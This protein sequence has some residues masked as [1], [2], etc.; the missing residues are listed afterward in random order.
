MC[1]IILASATGN[2]TLTPNQLARGTHR[3]TATYNGDTTYA[4]STSSPPQTLTV[5]RRG[6]G[7]AN[8]G[9]AANGGH[10]RPLTWGRPS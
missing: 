8:G 7:V 10:T 4:K 6:S 5:T 9:T 1:T 3:I 2:C